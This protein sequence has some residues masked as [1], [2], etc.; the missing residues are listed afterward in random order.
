MINRVVGEFLVPKRKSDEQPRVASE[1]LVFVRGLMQCH[2]GT[3]II[4]MISH[5]DHH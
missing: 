3:R 5:V 1:H 2:S 4:G